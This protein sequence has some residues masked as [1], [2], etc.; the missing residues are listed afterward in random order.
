MP[1]FVIPGNHD[2]REPLRARTPPD[3]NRSAISK[4]QHR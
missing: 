1:V 2:A 3:P 4:W